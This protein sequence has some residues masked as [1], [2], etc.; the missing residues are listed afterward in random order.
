MTDY[1]EIAWTWMCAAGLWDEAR[2]KRDFDEHTDE[3]LA[4]DCILSWDEAT[5]NRD[6]LIA[7][8]ADLREGFER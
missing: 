4:D 5:L 1:K 8:I 2:I 6:R 7:A 3:E